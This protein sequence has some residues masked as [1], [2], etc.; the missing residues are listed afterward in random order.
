[1]A[2]PGGIAG[3]GCRTGC[4]MQSRC[5]GFSGTGYRVRS[6][7]LGIR[8]S[9]LIRYRVSG[10]RCQVVGIRHLVPGTWHP[11][12]GGMP[13]SR[14]ENPH[15]GYARCRMEMGDTPH[16]VSCLLHIGCARFPLPGTPARSSALGVRSSARIRYR[17]PGA[18][19]PGPGTRYQAPIFEKRAHGVYR[20]R[21]GR[22]HPILHRAS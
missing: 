11:I 7:V 2:R 20:D 3:V 15:T 5:A 16:P 12:P 13:G 10:T 14:F 17:V 8:P 9:A 19:Y 18:R 4:R 22:H 21:S 1:M 6:S